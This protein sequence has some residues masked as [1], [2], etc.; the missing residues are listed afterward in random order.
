MHRK[1]LAATLFLSLPLA[2]CGG[3]GGGKDMTTPP[4]SGSSNSKL[5]DLK[6]SETFSTTAGTM[7]GRFTGAST[8]ENV[9][10]AQGGLGNDVTV[11]YNADNGSY[12]V[13][14]NQAGINSSMAFAPADL[15]TSSSTANVYE[16]DRTVNGDPQTFL[17]Y[18]P[19]NPASG[20]S[21]VTYGAW[22][23]SHQG[24]S[25]QDF[26]TSFFVFGIR[27]PTDD[28]PRTGSATYGT[29]VDGFW[30]DSTGL[31]A[32]NG[33]GNV[34]ADFGSGQ[35]NGSF[36]I[37]GVN[38]NTRAARNL[39]T[40]TGTGSIS[41]NTFSGSFNGTGSNYK[42]DWD[43]GFFG[44]AAEELGG[45]FRVTDGGNQAVGVFVGKK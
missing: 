36:A 19:G 30:A 42:G 13:S 6:V 44:P 9:T 3:G 10:S 17:L 11:A 24:T 32:L 31:S 38:V 8:V 4:P 22:Q 5:T 28:M 45:T 29:V 33:A 37:G 26:E 18:V 1:I 39:D 12:T 34:T 16:F 15:N 20:L 2:A 7:S 41:G 35:V 40:F 21:Y 23:H 25:T 27:T 43:G 14:V